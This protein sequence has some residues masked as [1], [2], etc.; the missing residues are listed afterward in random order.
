MLLVAF[1][2][3]LI[4]LEI[5]TTN[6][7]S[8]PPFSLFPFCLIFLNQNLPLLLEPFTLYKALTHRSLLKLTAGFH[9]SIIGLIIAPISF[10]VMAD[11][12]H[13][14]AKPNA[15]T[16]ST[17]LKLFGFNI[18]QNN[19]PV[20]SSNSLSGSSESENEGRKYECQYCFR[21]FSNSQ[22]LGGHQNAHKKERQLLKRAQIQATRNLASSYVPTSMFSTFTPHPPHLLP[23]AM[24]PM[25]LQH[26][27]PSWF[28]TSHLSRPLLYGP[29]RCLEDDSRASDEGSGL[30]DRTS[31]AVAFARSGFAGED[32]RAHQDKGLGLNL[33]LSL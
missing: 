10:S 13:Y 16:N 22:A 4:I 25:A 17:N 32:D 15:I 27:S 26:H 21:E 9:L 3:I 5:F 30:H 19:V 20:D 18:L 8:F 6:Y 2:S 28:Y 11:I 33:H 23:P 29:E 12:D 7:I 31:S 1:S 24:V 14:Y